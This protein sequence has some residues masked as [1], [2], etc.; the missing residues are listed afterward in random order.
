M[1]S[2]KAGKGKPREDRVVL[3]LG[4]SLTDGWG[5]AEGSA[6]PQVL[7]E[8][9]RARALPFVCRMDGVPGDTSEGGLRRSR[10]WLNDPR[11]VPSV[12][13][14]Q[15]GANDIFQGFS[16]SELRDNLVALVES[17]QLDGT[18]AIVAGTLIPQFGAKGVEG[19]NG[20]YAEVARRTGARRID[21]LLNGVS[22]DPS[23][24]Q[25]D[26]AHPTAAGHRRMAENAWPLLEEVLV[27]LG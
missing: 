22:D 21:D 9:I 4:D 10:R 2:A 15:F 3:F 6:F 25:S 17:F 13:V 1:S 14:V 19:L 23:L 7:Q 5:V 24:L 11:G 18:V 8:K 12:V 26:G 16:L 27:A 20:V